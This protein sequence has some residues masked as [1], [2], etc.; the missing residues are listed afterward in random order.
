MNTKGGPRGYG[1]ET[2]E[3]DAALEGLIGGGTPGWSPWVVDEV[4]GTG[5][6]SKG[7]A[8]E[9]GRELESLDEVEGRERK[10]GSGRE[11][12]EKALVNIAIIA[13]L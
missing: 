3:V 2:Q 1:E 7:G 8:K 5:W 9:Q 11:C 13:S 4:E 6:K 12:A 10:E